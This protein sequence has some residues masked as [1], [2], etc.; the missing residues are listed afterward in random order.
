MILALGVSTDR[1]W[2]KFCHEFGKPEWAEDPKY[3]TNADRGANY[4]QDLR[5]KLENYL[6]ENFTKE[7]LADRCAAI[8]V[9]CTGCNTMDD[10]ITREQLAAMLYRYAEY[11][12]YDVTASGDLSGFA[13]ADTVSGWAE[14]AM[15]WSVGAG[16][17]QGDENGLTPTATAIR[18]QI[19]AI[20]M[21]F[22]ENVAK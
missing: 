16:L 14:E 9:P 19:A 6:V 22:C 5:P 20:L 8:K 4:F 15:S 7:E 13:D 12:G 17:I 3:I 1:Q 21:R 2:Q 11:K 18:A 10:P